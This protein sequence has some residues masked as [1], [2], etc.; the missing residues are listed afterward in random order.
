[1]LFYHL[2][3]INDATFPNANSRAFHSGTPLPLCNVVKKPDWGSCSHRKMHSH[4]AHFNKE[5][6]HG[7]VT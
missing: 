4:T 1:M 6:E 7:T 2:F 3:F 5:T